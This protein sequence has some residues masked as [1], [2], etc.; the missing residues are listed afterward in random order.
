[1]FWISILSLVWSPAVSVGEAPAPTRPPD[2]FGR[3]WDAAVQ[4]LM[5]FPKQPVNHFSF[6]VHHKSLNLVHVRAPVV[7]LKDG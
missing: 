2:A 4:A 7:S 6:L 3:R 1:M 5:P